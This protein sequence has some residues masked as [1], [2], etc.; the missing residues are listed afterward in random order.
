[1]REKAMYLGRYLAKK[2]KRFSSDSSTPSIVR[3]SF[4]KKRCNV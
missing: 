3:S 1:L 2:C 4:L